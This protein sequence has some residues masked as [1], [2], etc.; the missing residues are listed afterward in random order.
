MSR[1]SCRTQRMFGECWHG[2]QRLVIFCVSIGC[3]CQRREHSKLRVS[4]PHMYCALTKAN[5]SACDNTGR[6]GT[7]Q[8]YL[9]RTRVALDTKTF[10]HSWIHYRSTPEVCPLRLA[11]D[12]AII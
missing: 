3:C 4:A 2:A 7:T 1:P 9:K 6:G 10:A 12:I 11:D 8:R 5:G